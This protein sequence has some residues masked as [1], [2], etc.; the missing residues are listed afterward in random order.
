CREVHVAERRDFAV[1]AVDL[2]LQARQ[3]H[4]AFLDGLGKLL[5]VGLCV[6]QLLGVL[7]EAQACG[8][9]LELQIGDARAQRF[10]IAL[11]AQAFFV[12]GAQLGRQVVVFAD[13]GRQFF[14]ALHLERQCGLQAGL[15]RRVRQALLLGTRAFGLFGH[16][17]GLLVGG[18]DGALQLGLSRRKR[19][20]RKSG[21]LRFALDGA[22]LF[23][24]RRQGT[25]GLDDFFF[26]FGMALLV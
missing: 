4:A 25:L 6:G 9:F 7:L 12:V 19:T 23:A 20:Q 17:R 3:A 14:F 16:E 2:A 21:F 13:L 1:Q 22:L 5:E 8:L 11:D 15:R 18:F 24:V 10:Q 26:E